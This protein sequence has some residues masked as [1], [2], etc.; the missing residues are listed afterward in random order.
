MA[1]PTAGRPTGITFGLSPAEGTALVI[2]LYVVIPLS[3]GFGIYKLIGWLFYSGSDEQPTLL[4]Y[5]GLALATAYVVWF[6]FS[7]FG[8]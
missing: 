2:F 8:A 1:F 6:C 5:I 7:L 3:I 4:K